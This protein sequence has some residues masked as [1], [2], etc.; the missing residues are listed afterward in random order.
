MNTLAWT[1][2]TVANNHIMQTQEASCIQSSDQMEDSTYQM[3]FLLTNHFYP[4]QC[5]IKGDERLRKIN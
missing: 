5:K 3:D 1:Q 2:T 4:S